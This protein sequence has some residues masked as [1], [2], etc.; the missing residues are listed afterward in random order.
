MRTIAVVNLKGG[1]GKTTT[2]L[3]LAVGMARRLPKRK[4]ILLIDGDPQA[5]MTMAMLEGCPAEVPTLG[6]VLLDQAAAAAAIRTTRLPQVDILPSDSDLANCALLLAEELGRERR[7]RAALRSVESDYE[8]CVI[9]SPP[10]LS[11]VSVNILQ[12]VTEIVVPVDAGLWSVSGLGRLQETVEQVRKHLDHAE[13]RIIGLV[14]TRAQ[15]NR[16]T[17]DLERQ[18]REAYGDLVYETVI[19]LSVKVEES[20]ARHRSV[21]EH[22]P[23]SPAALAYEQLITE[24]VKRHGKKQRNARWADSIDGD[25][26]AA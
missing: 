7:L 6:E 26:D 8:V 12:A 25:V 22:A 3:A 23:N 19:P 9:D 13:L 21:L 18:L 5:N 17:R 4:R 15:K 2:A 1:S 20:H 10:Q 16:A 11:L 24:V 14:L